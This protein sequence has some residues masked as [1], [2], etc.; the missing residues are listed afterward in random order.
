M[1]EADRRDD[2]PMAMLSER[3]R[4]WTRLVQ[5]QCLNHRVIM[6]FLEMVSEI[7]IILTGSQSSGNTYSKQA[8]SGSYG[9]ALCAAWI[10]FQNISL[11]SSGHKNVFWLEEETRLPRWICWFWKP[12]ST[13]IEQ[14]FPMGKKHNMLLCAN[15]SFPMSMILLTGKR[16]DLSKQQTVTA[17]NGGNVST[18]DVRD[19]TPA[20]SSSAQPA[21]LLGSLHSATCLLRLRLWLAPVVLLNRMWEG[22]PQIRC[23]SVMPAARNLQNVAT[24]NLTWSVWKYIGYK[25]SWE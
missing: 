8:A 17:A 12:C 10:E 4:N 20:H 6:P 18:W 22:L 19:A 1:R 23:F 21:E 7:M 14:N 25:K 11:S 9:L 13:F 24:Q 5:S 15:I 3:A 16:I 2:L